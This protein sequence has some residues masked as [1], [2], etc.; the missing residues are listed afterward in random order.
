MKSLLI[1]G[2][3]QYGKVVEELA[4]ICGYEKINALDDNN[5]EALD[6][7]DYFEKY[8]DQFEDCVVAI[9]NANI[10]KE[11]TEKIRPYFNLATIVHPTAIISPNASV[12]AGCIIEPYVVIHREAHIGD[13]CIINAAAVINHDSTVGSY[14]QLCCNSVVPANVSVPEGSKLGHCERWDG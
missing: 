8:V 3:G 10:R 5:P 9:G 2:Y 6:K 13:A 7:I 14:S 12:G 4:G 1:I 11:L